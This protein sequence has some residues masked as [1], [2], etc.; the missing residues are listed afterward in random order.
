MGGDAMATPCPSKHPPLHGMKNSEYFFA[1]N[2]INIFIA[3]FLFINMYV[4]KITEKS[5]K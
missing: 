4:P 1:S 5:N 2:I 3:F